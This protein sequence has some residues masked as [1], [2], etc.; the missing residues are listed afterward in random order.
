[1]VFSGVIAISS[2]A[3]RIALSYLLRDTYGN[4]VIA[5][6]EAYAWCFMLA[7]YLLRL[8]RKTQR[9]RDGISSVS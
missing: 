7:M 5:W 6:A 1:M 3:L 9:K 2:L 4:M 8:T